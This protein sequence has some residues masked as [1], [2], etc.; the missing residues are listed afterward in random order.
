M[1]SQKL[2]V[3]EDDRLMWDLIEDI[4]QSRG[5]EFEIFPRGSIVNGQLLL[6]NLKGEKVSINA[7]DYLVALVDGKLSM[8]EQDG[9]GITAALRKLGLPVIAVSGANF[10]NDEMIKAG[11]FK[12]IRKDHLWCGFLRGKA[13][14]DH[15]M[16]VA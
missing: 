10:L 15:L 9:V 5:V 6:T 12:A 13:I 3:V 16:K 4:L 7:E 11:A 14:Y 8:S 2:L 1:A